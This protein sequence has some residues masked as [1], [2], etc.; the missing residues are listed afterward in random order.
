MRLKLDPAD[1]VPIYSQ[2]FDQVRC[3]IAAGVLRPDDELP[4]VRALATEH[5]INPN[6]VARAYLEL[7]REG[8]LTKKRG[9]GTYVSP[10]AAR[11]GEREK[12]RI[13]REL[14][15]K[16]LAQAMQLQIPV[17]QVRNLFE[18]RLGDIAARAGKEARR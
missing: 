1:P 9:A 11:L 7:E 10:Q 3:A 6:T 12:A 17:K 2:I 18:E 15:D 5:L 16:A 14:L 13:V 4:S 8:F